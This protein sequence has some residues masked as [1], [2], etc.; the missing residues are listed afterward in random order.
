M[1]R[2]YG[3]PVLFRILGRVAAVDDDGE[4]IVV[5]ARR[6]R[7]LLARLILDANRVVGS[8]LLVDSV[9]GS[10]MPVHPEAAL[11][12]VVS[13]LRTALGSCG[14]RIVADASGY[15]LEAGPEEID[16]LWAESLLRDGRLA[17]AS[18]EGARAAELFDQALSL[19]DGAALQGLEEFSFSVEAAHRMH[20]LRVTLVEA[21]NDAYL[22]DG[23]H[24]EILVDIDSWVAEEPLREHLRAQ[25]IAALYRAG[26]QADAMRACE[27]LRK[28][29]R[30]EV[31]LNPSAEIQQLERRVLNQDPGLVA[32]D[33]GFMTALPAWTSELL[34]Y[35]GREEQYEEILKRF[36]EAVEGSVRLVLV[37]GAPGVGKSRFLL[38][39]AR[40]L[41]RDAIVLPIHV[42]DVFSPALHAVARVI[43]EAT[44]SLSDGELAAL[45]DNLGLAPERASR[46]RE[47]AS[48]LVAGESIAGL[49]G[50]ELVLRQAARWIAALSMKAPVVVIVDDLDT[51][52]PAVLHVVA[53]L[54]SLSMPERILVVGSLRSRVEWTSPHLARVTAAL[55]TSGCVVRVELPPLSEQDIDELLTRMRVAPRAALVSRL[56]ELTG[57]NALLLAELLS[58]GPPERVVNEWSSPPRIR[59]LVRKRTAELG[60]PT[61]EILKH[62]SLFLHDFTVELLAET[63]GTTIGTTATLVDRAVD[64]HVLQP[65]TIHSYRFAHQLFGQAL[66]ADLSADQRADGHRRIACALERRGSPPALLAAH[67]SG[68]SGAD[69][70]EKVL[71]YA[72]TAGQQS[73]RILESAAAVGWFE[74]A[75]QYVRDPAD[76]GPLLAELAQAQQFAGD[77]RCIETLQEAVR[78]ALIADDDELTLQIIRATTPGWS[79]LPGVTGKDT[80]RLLARALEVV[81]DDSATRSRILARLAVDLSLDD[82]LAAERTAD[83]AV[84][85]ARESNDRTALLESLMRRAS[86]SLTPHSLTARRLALREIL[87]LSS[88]STDVVTR[89]FALSASV[90]AAIQASDLVEAECSSTEADAIAV[91]YD[92]SPLE[93]S[94]RARRAWRAGLAGQLDEAEQLILDAWNYGNEHGVAHAGEAARL[95]RVTLRWQQNRLAELLPVARAAHDDYSSRSPGITIILIRALA[96]RATGHDEART[97]LSNL[98]QDEFARLPMG[99]FWCTA[100]IVAAEAA[101]IT[102]LPDVS[103]T[104]RDLLLP[105][106]D[107]VAFTGLWVTAPIAYGVAVACA[108]CDDRRA[109]KFFRHAAD[110]AERIH[111][112]VLA[113]RALEHPHANRR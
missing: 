58:T 33:G 10:A 60:R 17:L 82:P 21:R 85:L 14:R 1:S 36:A 39:I 79:T 3:C 20:Q 87:E 67:W 64:A 97:L 70:P 66:A 52:S 50:D 95:Q 86:F 18:N 6:Q 15:R 25:Q 103:T 69:A 71:E 35:V 91:H 7:A 4:L 63:A 8:S 26:R 54:A 73:L 100:L 62:A 74:L 89:Y 13:R 37:D 104:I 45:A 92:L 27:S 9:W 48:A 28:A 55:E 59:D 94:V 113:A 22:M 56:E 40:L 65:S 111:A 84:A 44:L 80:Q 19:W 46:I 108:G 110:I 105:F 61:A 30:N 11:Q 31:G 42:H 93:W 99:T 24:I 47:V 57:G 77:P 106:V 98:A 5:G 51:A 112:P 76:R 38:Q 16:V 101:C 32:T 12:V 102:G 43:A 81:G 78:V 53:Q 107:Q 109:P 2:G 96:E 68:A 90:V 75:L 41:S 72:Q 34:A 83:E 23:R 88:R 49:V 29:L